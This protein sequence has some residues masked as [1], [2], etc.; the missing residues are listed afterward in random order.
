MQS[1][2]VGQQATE[3]DSEHLRL[4]D[5]QK[6]LGMAP[7]NPAAEEPSKTLADTVGFGCTILGWLLVFALC[8]DMYNVPAAEFR[9]VSSDIDKLDQGVPPR[10]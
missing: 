8:L 5:A 9:R 3:K 4:A 1:D 10:C 7:A 2:H 6:L